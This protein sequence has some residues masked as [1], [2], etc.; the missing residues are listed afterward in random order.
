M[1]ERKKPGFFSRL[2]SVTDAPPEAPEEEKAPAESEDAPDVL[3]SSADAEEIA[4]ASGEE[5]RGFSRWFRRKEK[6]AGEAAEGEPAEDERPAEDIVGEPRKGWI[7]RLTERLGK[8]RQNLV[9]SIRSILGM[10]GKLDDETIEEIE[11][12]LIQSDVSVET[13]QK[14]IGRMKAETKKSKGELGPEGLLEVFKHAVTD[15]LENSAP[16]FEPKPP[17]AGAPYV[18]LVVGVNGVGKTTTIA[19]MAKRCTDRGLRTMLVAGDTFRA[20]AVEQ[21]EIWANRTGCEF[22]KGAHGSDPAALCYDALQR[23]RARQCQVVFIDTAGRLHTK[24]TLMEELGKIERVIRKQIPDAPHET[25]LVLDATTGQNAIQQTRIF[26]AAVR[27]TGLVM[28]KLDGTARGG[29]L[30]SVLDMFRIPITLIGVGES[31]EDLRDFDPAQYTTALFG[32][33]EEEKSRA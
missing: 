18:V 27:V 31:A 21:L 23:A 14:I 33:R 24:S 9:G 10:S 15:I 20:A 19:K 25:L 2:W 11:A 4:A 29:V 1:T 30:L 16:G 13:A 28:T 12:V 32:E 3:E 8:T 17:E 6:P 7:A 26:S 5:R 22:A